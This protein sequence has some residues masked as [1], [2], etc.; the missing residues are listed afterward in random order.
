MKKIYVFGGGE[1]S[2][3]QTYPLDRLV[4]SSINKKK[5]KVLFIPTASH[6][7]EGYVASFTRI[8]ESLGCIVDSLQ[9]TKGDNQYP[10]IKEKIMESDLIYV[11]GGDTLFMLNT[12]KEYKVDELLIEAYEN[13]TI[14]SGLSAGGIC[15]FDY[16]YS[17]S[18]IIEG[19]YDYTYVEGLHLI[20]MDHNP[21][22]DEEDRKGFLDSFKRRKGK[23]IS[24]DNYTLACFEDGELKKG[25]KC[26]DNAKILLVQ[27]NEK[28]MECQEI[29]SE[30]ICE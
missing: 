13:N 16:G 12:W 2:L 9:I 24:M 1:T 5:P 10:T 7:A 26:T 11:R 21:H 29:L 8:Y 30:L 19:G 20:K 17:D 6:D 28:G 14:L 18:L 25:Y 15:W 3:K 22:A 4:V 27:N 23:A